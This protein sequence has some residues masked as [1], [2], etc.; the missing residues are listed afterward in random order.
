MGYQRRVHGGWNARSLA[1]GSC[2]SRPRRRPRSRPRRT[3]FHSDDPSYRCSSLSVAGRPE[4]LLPREN[5][6]A[7]SLTL[8]GLYDRRR[9]KVR[10]TISIWAAARVKPWRR[11]RRTETKRGRGYPCGERWN[12]KILGGVWPLPRFFGGFVEVSQKPYSGITQPK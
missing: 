9:S 1:R 11:R 12:F 4:N 5:R 7:P 2:G 8:A 6:S 10:G 3:P